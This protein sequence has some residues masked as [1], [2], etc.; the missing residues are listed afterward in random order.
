[1]DSELRAVIDYIRSGDEQ[2]RIAELDSSASYRV[3][4]RN[5]N[6]FMLT[7]VFK[8]STIKHAGYIK[9]GIVHVR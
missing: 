7:A 2:N 5:A 8:Q 6:V 1:M 4:L 9:N 3:C